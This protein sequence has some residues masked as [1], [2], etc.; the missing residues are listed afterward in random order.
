MPTRDD[1]DAWRDAAIRARGYSP[2]QARRRIGE[3]LA[4]DVRLAGTIATLQRS[5]RE[6]GDELRVLRQIARD[7]RPRRGRS[8]HG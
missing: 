8:R 7:G 3:L 4:Q 2:P 1:A 5:R 6:I